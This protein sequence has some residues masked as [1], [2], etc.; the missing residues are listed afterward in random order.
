MSTPVST[1]VSS[2][3]SFVPATINMLDDSKYLLCINLA[4]QLISQEFDPI[5]R[6]ISFDLT[7]G[8]QEY[9]LST[10]T[11]IDITKINKLFNV[12]IT[13]GQLRYELGIKDRVYKEELPLVT[14]ISLP[15]RF[16]DYRDG[17]NWYIG[18]YPQPQ[19][20]LSA[21][22]KLSISPD[23]LNSGETDTQIPDF[24][25]ELVILIACHHASHMVGNADLG[26]HFW[27]LYLL[28]RQTIRTPLT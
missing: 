28:K 12:T 3:Q 1:Y 18:F 23:E 4:R 15:T 21:T 8:Q 13:F 10:V 7:E 26:S 6:Y 9:N 24:L 11:Q 19:A 14:F 2:I 20:N 25:R 22:V 5:T 17:S 16:Y 27:N